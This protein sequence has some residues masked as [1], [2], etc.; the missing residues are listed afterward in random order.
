MTHLTLSARIELFPY[1]KPFRISG[2]VFTETAVVLVELSDGQST[3][4]GESAGVYYL[5]DDAAAIMAAI[6]SVRPAIE[7]GATRQDLQALLPPGGARNALDC[8]YWDLEA[9]QSGRPAWQ[10]AGLQSP[11]QLPTTITLGAD[12]PEVMAA[13]AA[14]LDTHHIKLKLTG[15]AELDAARVAAVRAV[16]PDA[17]IG[18]DAN[19]GYKADALPALFDMLLTHSI[20]LLEQPLARGAEAD[21]DEVDRPIPVAADESVLSLAE[22]DRLPGRFDVLNIKLDKCGGLTE[23]LA[24]AG[25]AREMGLD[26][27]VGNMMGSS[28]AMA[29]SF[30]LG[31]LCDVVDLDGPTFLATDRTPAVTYTDG[32]IDCP[33]ELWGGAA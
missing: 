2:H 7:A 10:L 26:V 11:R 24:M 25:R 21:M 14:T 12:A 20:A 4:R 18:V 9:A 23:A 27:M 16:R 31:Q 22:M 3:G 1:K 28:L 29:P 30:L 8:A 19:Q 15:E 13:A 5:N 6:E 17:W 32:K 33:A